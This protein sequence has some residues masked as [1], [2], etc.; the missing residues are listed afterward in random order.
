[1]LEIEELENNYKRINKTSVRMT[2]TYW[3][4]G[5]MEIVIHGN[6]ATGWVQATLYNTVSGAELSIEF[7]KEKKQYKINNVNFAYMDL[8]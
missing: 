3:N 4:K 1:M 2:K 5:N 6:G 7:N 8:N